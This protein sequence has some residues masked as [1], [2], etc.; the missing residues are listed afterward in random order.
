VFF[1]G[2]DAA[3]VDAARGQWSA[4]TKAGCAAQYWGEDGGRWQMKAQHP[5]PDDPV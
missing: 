3:A 1:D 5:R 2:A 4:L